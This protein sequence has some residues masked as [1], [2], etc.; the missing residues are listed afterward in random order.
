MIEYVFDSD[1]SS[2]DGYSDAW[3]SDSEGNPYESDGSMGEDFR[4]DDSEMVDESEERE[5]FGDED[6]E[7]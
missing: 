4:Y 7:D 1:Q 6:E 3:D 5:H 2:F